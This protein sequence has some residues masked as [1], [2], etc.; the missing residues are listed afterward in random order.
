VIAG[1]DGVDPFVAPVPL[2]D[3]RAVDLG[4]LRVA[5]HADNGGASPTP[6]TA[7]AVRAA[8][9]ALSER[10]ARVTE[11]LPPDAGSSKALWVRL[12]TADGGAGVRDLLTRLGTQEIHP[13]VQ[14]TQERE[15]ISSADLAR[16]LAQWNDLRRRNLAFLEGF[17]AIVCP[18][19]PG[20]APRHDEPTAYDYTYHYNLLGWP[21]AVVR[22]T[23]SPEGLPIGLQVVAAPWREDVA[24]AAARVLEEVFG[25]WKRVQT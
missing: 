11:A 24:V 12:M 6:E 13:L 7:A 21:A 14:W 22:C 2:G 3:E 8:A 15:A 4:A 20:P 1:P 18:V 16:A 5:Y 17:D 19:T 10:G 9:A 25:G 23:S